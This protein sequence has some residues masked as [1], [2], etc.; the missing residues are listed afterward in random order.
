M[1]VEGVVALNP[2]IEIKLGVPQVLL[3]DTPQRF[4]RET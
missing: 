2:L 4:R 1:A 3:L